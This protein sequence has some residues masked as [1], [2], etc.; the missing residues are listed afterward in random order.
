MF[1]GLNGAEMKKMSNIDA[2]V[3]PPAPEVVVPPIRNSVR[4]LI[5]RN[6]QVLL[7]R[8]CRPGGVERYAMPGGGQDAGERLQ[9]TLL[10]ECREEIDTSVDIL[11]LVHVAESFKPCNGKAVRFRQQVEFVF[12]CRLPPDYE[13]RS[14]CR[15]DKHQVAVE[16]VG[17]QYL[18]DIELR[19]RGMAT[20]VRQAALGE[21]PVYL[22]DL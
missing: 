12:H 4:A 8:K 17:L 7:L 9:D 11:G 22:G 2:L 6:N 19:P 21:G 13:P 10:R 18:D 5:V 1:L 16:W 14:G 3:A 20:L 15:P